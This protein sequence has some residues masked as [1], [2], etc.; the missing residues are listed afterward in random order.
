MA[1]ILCF[2]WCRRSFFLKREGP[3]AEKI[4]VDLKKCNASWSLK[5]VPRLAIAKIWQLWMDFKWQNAG[6]GSALCSMGHRCCNKMWWVSA[7]IGL[8]Y[9]QHNSFTAKSIPAGTKNSRSEGFLLAKHTAHKH[10]HHDGSVCLSSGMFSILEHSPP[11]GASVTGV[12][13]GRHQRV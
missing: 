9:S 1:V 2:C 12:G 3:E 11:P 4:R 13:Q 8:K 6:V 5:A 7:K 10:P